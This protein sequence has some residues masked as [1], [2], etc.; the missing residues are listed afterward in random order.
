MSAPVHNPDGTLKVAGGLFW[1][2]NQ[3]IMLQIFPPLIFLGVGALTDF[4]PLIANPRTLLLGG[5]AQLGMFITFLVRPCSASILQGRRLHRRHRRGRRPDLHLHRHQA[6][7]R[8]CSAPSPSPPTATWPW[9]P[10]IQPPI[11]KLLTTD[12]E[13][14]I[15]MKT[16]RK[17]SQLEKLIFAAGCHGLLHPASSRAP[18]R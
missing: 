14:K 10:L 18:R 2:L 12:K 16:L 4:G 1:Y 17:V 9:C 15:S 5:A 7:A 11:M 13:R 3:G 6:R 8:T